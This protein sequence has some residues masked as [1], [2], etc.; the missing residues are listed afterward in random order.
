MTEFDRTPRRAI[1]DGRG[2]DGPSSLSKENIARGNESVR[3]LEE[4]HFFER[5]MPERRVIIPEGQAVTYSEM[6][7][8]EEWTTQGRF[9]DTL[10]TVSLGGDPDPKTG[11]REQ[12]MRI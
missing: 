8:Y 5:R 1:E 2:G 11:L 10:I 9:G 3:N 7:R 6:N 12:R 4:V